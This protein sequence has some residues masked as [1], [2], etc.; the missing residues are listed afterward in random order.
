M[1]GEHRRACYAVDE[2]GRYVV[3]PSKGWSVEAIVNA[4]ANEEVNRAIAAAHARVTAGRASP[5]AYHMARCQMIPSLL[6]A[7]AGVSV[8]RVYWHLRPKVFAR[9]PDSVLRRYADALGT[10]IATLR[11]LPP[12]PGR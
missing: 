5:L 8:L 7:N 10:D 2:Q 1:L 12:A 6:A 4:Q 3:V 11:R 9:L